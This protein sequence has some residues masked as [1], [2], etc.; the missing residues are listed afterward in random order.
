MQGR[1]LH[2][3]CGRKMS[4]MGAGAFEFIVETK[5]PVLRQVYG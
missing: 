1:K 5:V 3:L 4:H 2:D